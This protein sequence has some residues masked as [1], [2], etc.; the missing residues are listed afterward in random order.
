MRYVKDD[1]GDKEGRGLT[2]GGRGEGKI[3]YFINDL[4]R[5]RKKRSIGGAA[6]KMRNIFSSLCPSNSKKS[7]GRSSDWNDGGSGG[8]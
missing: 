2:V 8:G 5:R 3:L 1:N 7:I 6:R 4:W